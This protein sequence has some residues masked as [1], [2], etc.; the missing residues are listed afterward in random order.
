MSPKPNDQPHQ[1]ASNLNNDQWANT[2]GQANPL[3]ANRVTVNQKIVDQVMAETKEGFDDKLNPLPPINLTFEDVSIWAKM[4]H[5]TGF[6]K[7]RKY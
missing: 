4:K 6:C 1:Q 3:N 5:R 7:A 2:D